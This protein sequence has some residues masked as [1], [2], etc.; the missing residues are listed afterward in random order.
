LEIIESMF[1][2]FAAP[3]LQGARPAALMPV[4]QPHM[5]TWSKRQRTLRRATGL[6]T[7]QI[8]KRDG[9]LLVL[10]YD[11]DKL[12]SLLMDAETAELLARYGYPLSLGRTAVLKHLR[13]R[14]SDGGAGFPHEI[15]AFLGYPMDD[16]RGFIENNGRNCI[17]C[18]YWKVYHD[19]ERA[20]EIFKKIDE[21]RQYA[22]NLLRESMP[23]STAAG[24]LK[25]CLNPSCNDIHAMSKKDFGRVSMSWRSPLLRRPAFSDQQ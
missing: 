19:V 4:K 13:S 23:I 18:R 3:V 7:L 10:I 24:L 25:E 14:F 17:C 5:R 1:L 20:Q 16:V 11:G 15:G 2:D 12:G 9:G 8:K 21:A 22:R 6:L